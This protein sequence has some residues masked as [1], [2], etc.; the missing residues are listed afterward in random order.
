M[1]SLPMFPYID[2]TEMDRFTKAYSEGRV[3]GLTKRR[4]KAEG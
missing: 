4:E 1:L 2:A 3:L